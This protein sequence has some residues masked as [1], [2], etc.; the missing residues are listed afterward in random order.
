M[1]SAQILA[2]VI[3][4]LCLVESNGNPKAVN[5][6]CLGILQIT[7]IMIAD[8]NRIAGREKWKKAD[9]FSAAKSKVMALEY[10]IHYSEDWM[11][12]P[13]LALLWKKGPTGM[14]RGR[15][16]ADKSYAE[17]VNNLAQEMLKK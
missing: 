17:R 1:I 3:E 12:V 7:P 6:E 15:S 2:V 9:C 8:L 14:M 10:L 13:S 16:K 5:G 11:D 4:A